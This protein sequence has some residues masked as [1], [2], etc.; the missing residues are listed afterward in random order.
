[1]ALFQEKRTML[2]IPIK[3]ENGD[4]EIVELD[5][6]DSELTFNEIL[7]LFKSEKAKLS[8]WFQ[9]AVFYY[10]QGSADEFKSILEEAHKQEQANNVNKG[11]DHKLM[12]VRV[13][14]TL[15]AYYMKESNNVVRADEKKACMEKATALYN[16]ADEF[17]KFDQSNLVGKGF[18]YIA[19]NEFDKAH[20]ILDWQLGSNNG[21]N[22]I[23]ALLGKACILFNTQKYTAALKVYRKVLTVNPNCPASVRVGMGV[24]YQRLNQTEKAKAAF[25]RARALD[26]KNVG[27]MVGVAILGM[28]SNT[29]EGLKDA[30]KLFREAYYIGKQH[31]K[32]DAMVLNHLANIIFT[33]QVVK[34][35]K[36]TSLQQVLTLANHAL[37]S[38]SVE[39][40]QA[41]S[42]FQL[43]RAYHN[44]G[45]HEQAFKFYYKATKLAPNL[46]LAQYGLGQMYIGKGERQKAS[47]CFEK[48]WKEYP[49]N[50]E[51]LKILGSLYGKS[52]NLRKREKAIGFLKQVAKLKPKDFDNWIELAMLREPNDKQGAIDSYLEALKLFEKCD[53]Q[54]PAEILNNLGSLYSQINKKKEAEERYNQ[55]LAVLKAENV[56]ETAEDQDVVDYRNGITVTVRYNLARLSETGGAAQMF[57]RVGQLT[58]ESNGLAE[59]TVMDLQSLD[60]G[61]WSVRVRTGVD[62]EGEVNDAGDRK[63]KEIAEVGSSSVKVIS[64]GAVDTYTDLLL[65]HSNY[66][67]CHLSIASIESAKGNFDKAHTQLDLALSSDQNNVNLL[68]AKANLYILAKPPKPGKAQKIYETITSES[69][70]EDPYATLA[71]GNIWLAAANSADSEKKKKYLEYARDNYKIVLKKDKKNVYA[72][73]GIGCILA[74]HGRLAEAKDCFISAREA[75][76]LVPEPWINLAHVYVEQKNFA[77]AIKMYENCLKKF[78]NNNDTELLQYL[79]RACYKAQKYDECMTAAQKAVLIAPENLL[80]KYNLALAC[81]AQAETILRDPNSV[82]ANVEQ[83][84]GHLRNARQLFK[85]LQHAKAPRVNLSVA[86]QKEQRCNEYLKQA[87]DQVYRAKKKAEDRERDRQAIEQQRQSFE[88][89]RIQKAKLAVEEK[90]AVAQDKLNRVQKFQGYVEDGDMLN[91]IVQRKVAKVARKKKADSDTDDNGGRGS[92]GQEN[93]KKRKATKSKRDGERKQKKGRKLKKHDSDSDSDDDNGKYKSQKYVEDD[94]DS[95]ADLMGALKDKDSS[96]DEY[97][98]EKAKKSDGEDDDT[99]DVTEPKTVEHSDVASDDDGSAKGN[100]SGDE[101]NAP[102]V[103]VNAM[104]EDSD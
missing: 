50:Y 86:A 59:G 29:T 31:N 101:N 104:D 79:A 74:H 75:A 34:A 82:L 28:N 96:A 39:A 20:K 97:D 62:G 42:H 45:E 99:I 78:Y 76:P 77:N 55:A 21:D 2:E 56:G 98:P 3:D 68:T 100:E 38:S 22:H 16:K 47:E 11:D 18:L 37:N 57:P 73:N 26:P 54:V 103:S 24:C 4:E 17:S 94:D 51:T 71:L 84:M 32:N 88:Q 61:K 63:E 30:S 64:T 52:D 41:E 67:D 60:D 80:F 48:V 33:N 69:N 6:H 36:Q 8:L 53:F 10:Q 93:K 90:L 83:A 40:I 14:T 7:E 44:N 15:A 89:D 81:L 91:I 95:D 85:F 25:D 23:P 70:R 1:M 19:R 13:L 87:K 66:T 58:E 72:A 35:K 12:K 102:K 65:D 46:I 49:D 5:L 27:A 43:A 9:L 92:P